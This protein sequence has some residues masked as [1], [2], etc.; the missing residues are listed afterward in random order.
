MGADCT[1]CQHL[2]MGHSTWWEFEGE[3]EPKEIVVH[4]VESILTRYK[5]LM[6]TNTNE[7]FT[8]VSWPNK[9]K[10]WPIYIDCAIVNWLQLRTGWDQAL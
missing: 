2:S 5:V 3:K 9:L 8:W 1:N 6:I 10:T 4:G 7:L